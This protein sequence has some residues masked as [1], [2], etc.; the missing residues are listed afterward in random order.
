MP[1]PAPYTPDAVR[2]I[3]TQADELA[4]PVIAAQLHWPVPRLLRIAQRH[5][6]RVFGA[7]GKPRVVEDGEQQPQRPAPRKLMPNCDDKGRV[8]FNAGMSL[9]EIMGYLPK[10]QR[11]VVEMLKDA[12][13]DGM[14]I[15]EMVRALGT[16][17][18]LGSM[19]G[20]IKTV[21]VKLAPTLWCVRPIRFAIYALLLRSEL[22]NGH[23]PEPVR[24]TALDEC[25]VKLS[26]RQCRLL[27]LL[28]GAKG[29]TLPSGEIG[30]A[31]QITSGNVRDD[32][33]AIR[34]QLAATEWKIEATRGWD[35]GFRLVKRGQ[36]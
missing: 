22:I 29:N 32:V 8:V 18:S 35:G 30:T 5:G 15:R 33:R 23:R 7:D 26:P 4:A 12:G 34:R 24:A 16:H 31:L 1:D 21:D 3:R 19:G 20:L 6:I 14:H 2:V 28:Q 25:M 10:R 36:G 13:P 11:Q 9:D 17:C 27:A